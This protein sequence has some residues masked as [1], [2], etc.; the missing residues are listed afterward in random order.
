MSEVKAKWCIDLINE[1]LDGNIDIDQIQNSFV[2]DLYLVAGKAYNKMNTR[3]D[4]WVSIN[5]D[6][7]EPI[8]GSKILGF[9]EGYAFECEFDD[10]V[11]ANIGG[12]QFTHWKKL[13]HP[14]A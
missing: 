4:G 14:T 7:P 10:G 11:W 1:A 9:G 3:S 2:Q 5:I 6:Q 8:Q 12:E 13:E